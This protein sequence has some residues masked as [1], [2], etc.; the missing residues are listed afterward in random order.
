[1]LMWF[2]AAVVAIIL[3]AVVAFSV[4]PW[5]GALVIRA[6]FDRGGN[7]TNAVLATYVPDSVAVARDIVYRPDDKD[8]RLDV[9]YPAEVEGTDQVLPTILWVHGGGWLAGAKERLDPWARIL[10]DEGFA[11]IAVDYTL[12]PSAH[13]PYQLQ[14]VLDAIN[15]VRAGA[16]PHVDA[17]RLVLAGDSAGASLVAQAATAITTPAYAAQ[18]GVTTAATPDAV[19]GLIL[20]CGPYDLRIADKAGGLMGWAITTIGWAYAGEKNFLD[21]PLAET[22]SLVDHAYP[23]FP[24]VFISG[25]NGDPLTTTAKTYADRLEDAGNS[26]ERLF[27]ADDYTPELGHEYQFDLRLDAA[28]EALDLSLDFVREHTG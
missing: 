4:S 18:V 1:F 26:V 16:V 20:Y 6:S 17:E 3:V 15:A 27:F 28:R 23:G 10:A 5:P 12:A 19:A 9:Y 8:G 14:Q 25:G 7:E 13:Y 24:P 22:I 2:A 11:V 21:D